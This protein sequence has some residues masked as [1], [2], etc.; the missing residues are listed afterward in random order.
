MKSIRLGALKLFIKNSFSK[1]IK[2]ESG[3][4]IIEVLIAAAI[5][6][7]GLLA[8][9]SFLGNLMSQN[10]TSERKTKATTIAEE[11]IEYLRNQSLTMDIDSTD[12]GSDTVDI[13]TRTWSIDEDFSGLADK[14]TVLV[15]WE[16]PGNTKIT[17]VTLVN[18]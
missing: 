18:N 3:F 7:F 8:I 12:N 14:I 16:G 5:I 9:V 6:V 11:K 13:F 4:T 10:S 1:K 15:D 17:L 2:K